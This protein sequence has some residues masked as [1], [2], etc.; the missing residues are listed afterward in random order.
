MKNFDHPNIVKYYNFEEKAKLIKANGKEVD[1]AYL[2]MDAV[3]GGELFDFVANTGA[4]SEP[5][6]RYFFL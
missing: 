3:T 6:C 5:E 1:V 2:A 4:F